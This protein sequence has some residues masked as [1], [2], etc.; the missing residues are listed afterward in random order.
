MHRIDKRHMPEILK[1]DQ[2]SQVTST[3][4]IK[5]LAAGE[6]KI[7][8]D[9]KKAWRDHVFVERL[10]RIIKYEEVY[11]P[12]YVGVSEA[13]ASIS[14]YL[15]FDNSRRPHSSPDGKT[16]EQASFNQPIWLWSTAAIAATA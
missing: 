8:M 16:P 15:G 3:E 1:T 2:G 7:S 4:L 13:C 11:L 14:R 9:G 10:W 5:V 12:A 6:T